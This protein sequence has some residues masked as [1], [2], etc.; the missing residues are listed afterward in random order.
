MLFALFSIDSL[1]SL[2]NVISPFSTAIVQSITPS[3]RPFSQ[4]ELQGPILTHLSNLLYQ[5]LITQFKDHLVTMIIE[6]YNYLNSI[7]IRICLTDGE[8]TFCWKWISLEISEYTAATM[9][10]CI[11]HEISTLAANNIQVSGIACSYSELMRNA[12]SSEL[13][14]KQVILHNTPYISFMIEDI[15]REVFAIPK[16]N[17]MW[18]LVLFY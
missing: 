15:F 4:S 13:L 11:K 6:D 17:E 2:D 16:I 12:I 9:S 1:S 10:S 14:K 5:Y 7:L 3:I 8:M 18:N